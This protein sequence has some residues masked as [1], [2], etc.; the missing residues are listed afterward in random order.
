MVVMFCDN[1]W[2]LEIILISLSHFFIFAQWI[3]INLEHI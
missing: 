3:N 1:D 2:V